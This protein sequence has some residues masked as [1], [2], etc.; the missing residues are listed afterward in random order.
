MTFR[1]NLEEK[2][3]SEEKKRN[4]CYEFLFENGEKNKKRK[5][6]MM[7]FVRRFIFILTVIG[8]LSACAKPDPTKC[9]AQNPCPKGQQCQ[10]GR[11]VTAQNEKN[12]ENVPTEKLQK[13]EFL[14]NDGGSSENPIPDI[15]K[16][17]KR[18]LAYRWK[19]VSTGITVDLRGVSLSKTGKIWASGAQGQI[20]HSDDYGATWKRQT[21]PTKE[22]LRSI[23]FIDDKRG[24]IVGDKGIILQTTNGGR[25]WQQ[26]TAPVKETLHDVQFFDEN[27]GFAVGDDF[28]FLKTRDGGQHW[29]STSGSISLDIT[30]LHFLDR[31]IGFIA[32]SQGT[33]IY[34]R[35]GGQQLTTGVLGTKARFWSIHFIDKSE[36]WAAGEGGMLYHSTDSGEGWQKVPSG[37]QETLYGIDFA[38]PKRGWLIGAK[39][40]LR[41]TRDGGKHWQSEAMEKYN[42]LFDIHVRSAHKGVIVGEKGTIIIMQEL[43]GD[44][45]EG[46]ETECYTGPAK[47]KGVGRC[48]AGKKYCEDGLWSSCKGEILPAPKEIC[49]NGTDDN[50]NGKDDKADGCPDCRDGATKSCYTGPPQTN[51]T[52]NCRHGISTCT[53]G[54]WGPC[55]NEILPKKESCNGKDDDCNGKIDDNIKDLPHCTKWTGVCSSAR[56]Q[57]VK[58]RLLPCKAQQ[59]G[60]DYEVK[61]TK[62]DGKDNDCDGMI[63]EGCPC[64]ASDKP[65]TCYTGSYGT[66]GKGNCKAGTQICTKGKWS[67]CTK[68]LTPHREICDDKKDNDCDGYIDEK[69]QYALYFNARNAALNLGTN[70]AFEPTTNF[71]LE[72]WVYPLSTTLRTPQYILTKTTQKQ[73]G[74]YALLL[75][76]QGHRGTLAF[77]LWLDG[78]RTYQTIYYK[79]GRNFPTRHWYHLAGTFDGKMMKLWLNGKKVAEKSV[80]SNKKVAYPAKNV[81]LVAGAAST[82]GGISKTERAFL[83]GY[84]AEIRLSKTVLYTRPFGAECTMKPSSKTIAL[85]KLDDRGKGKTVDETGHYTGIITGA[86]WREMI[87]CKGFVKGGCLKKP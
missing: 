47:T 84:I 9:D 15:L 25:Q 46:D 62:C 11:C 10:S 68:Q 35:D 75:N 33:I 22:T 74:G 60:K 7:F 38:S 23:S 28:T 30:S 31:F 55:K 79:Y 61:E 6:E 78:S 57:C 16:D 45:F 70:K 1:K 81:P 66:L 14:S 87:R 49:F 12:I 67:Y 76:P 54:Q 42:D 69:N 20:W 63:D 2:R 40:T 73:G 64:K 43:P 8:V 21:S 18:P 48:Q 56:R 80:G 24:W 29:H 41:G 5:D 59:Y 77:S 19:R 26:L 50:C 4:I 27:N 71:T 3:S 65:R 34:T 53:N 85:W 82:I 51:G 13:R 36:G 83:Y 72:A 37:T 44:C 17:E 32:G 86:V 52:G 58:G 39:G